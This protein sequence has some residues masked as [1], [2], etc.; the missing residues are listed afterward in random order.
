MKLP[1]QLPRDKVAAALAAAAIAF[2]PVAIQEARATNTGGA[3]E[4]DGAAESPLLDE[5]LR[6]T[7]QNKKRN[8]GIVKSITESNAFTAIEG[9][10]PPSK[11]PVWEQTLPSAPN[12]FSALPK[13]PPLLDMACDANGRNC[14]F[15]T[16]GAAARPAGL[17][18]YILY[19]SSGHK[20]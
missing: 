13:P 10:T 11:A 3:F 1:V 20:K 5:L 17:S 8:A 7:E 16:S 4:V 15:D 6:R 9:Y 18:Q 19:N 14:K 2:S 12:P